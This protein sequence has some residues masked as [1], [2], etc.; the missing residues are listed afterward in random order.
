[1]V[2]AVNTTCLPQLKK[3]LLI[4]VIAA[5]IDVYFL[6]IMKSK[7]YLKRGDQA[8]FLQNKE[9]SMFCFPQTL[10]NIFIYCD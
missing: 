8:L 2:N 9:N 3:Y 5:C 1:M 4:K 6:L 7:N 10:L